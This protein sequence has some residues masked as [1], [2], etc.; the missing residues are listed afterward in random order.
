M[1]FSGYILVPERLKLYSHKMS[2]STIFAKAPIAQMGTDPTGGLLEPILSIIAQIMSNV[3]GGIL[4]AMRSAIN[5]LSSTVT[6]SEQDVKK[7]IESAFASI[8]SI[9]DGGINAISQLLNGV[10]SGGEIAV[11][12]ALNGVNDVLDGIESLASNAFSQLTSFASSAK[13]QLKSRSTQVYSEIDSLVNSAKTAIVN[14]VTS[15]LVSLKNE[16]ESIVSGADIFVNA[17]LS[18]IDRCITKYARAGESMVASA[19]NDVKGDVGSA[20]SGCKTVVGKVDGRISIIRA[21]LPSLNTVINAP[22]MAYADVM[23]TLGERSGNAHSSSN[24]TETVISILNFVLF[25]GTILVL[26][27]GY[28]K[29]LKPRILS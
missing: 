11:H 3:E 12:D 22:N 13:S 24:L 15:A 23:E 4:T 28:V 7:L 8:V 10:V 6:S 9:T 20:I 2:I 29:Y 5:E 21:S 17:A 1:Y 14:A 25:A 16:L 19:F 26:I 27:L 18:D